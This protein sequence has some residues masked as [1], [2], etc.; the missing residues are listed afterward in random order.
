MGVLQEIPP[1]PLTMLA[2]TTIYHSPAPGPYS[3]WKV[4][5]LH[6]PTHHVGKDEGRDEADEGGQVAMDEADDHHDDR[7][8]QV[9][10]GSPDHCHPDGRGTGLADHHHILKERVE[11]EGRDKWKLKQK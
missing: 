7:E 6:T 8:R 10:V 9:V 3:D 1:I 5:H 11:R 2:K 4:P